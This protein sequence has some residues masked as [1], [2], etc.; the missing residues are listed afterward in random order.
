MALAGIL[1][2]VILG[3][4]FP[5]ASLGAMVS[6]GEWSLKGCVD[7]ILVAL[8]QIWSY[9]FHDPVMTD[10]GFLT[11][12]KK[13]LKSFIL[14]G[15][16]GVLFIYLFGFVGLFNRAEGIGGNATID[17]AVAL[18]TVAMFMM[19]GIM[20]TSAASTLDS[21]FSS[22][23]KLISLDLL[24]DKLNPIKTG[25]MSMI[26]LAVL[27]GVMVHANPTI[28]SATTVSG[29]MVI[30]LAPV[31]LFSQMKKAGPASFYFSVIVGLICG[32]FLALKWVPFAVGEGKYGAL[33]WINI[34]GTIVSFAGYLLL[35]Y[36]MPA[37][38][39]EKA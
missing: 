16:F 18:G 39:Q 21:T 29:T 34:V 22:V 27:G 36:L 35:A 20:L 11:E 32:I 15:V 8:I 14:A 12:E 10:R 30:G 6:S 33:L 19:N 25:R 9:P 31:F 23:G 38:E 24:K 17:S 28:L 37:K 5:R 3:F 13:M 4:I 1:L 26:A 7:L 2:V